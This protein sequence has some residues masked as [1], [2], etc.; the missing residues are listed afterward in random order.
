[1]ADRSLR[2]E[3][4]HMALPHIGPSLSE[5]TVSVEIMG[6]AAVVIALLPTEAR[7]KVTEMLIEALPHHIEQRAREIASGA[8]DDEMSRRTN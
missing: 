1:M 2:D 6:A 7:K 4:L 5:I 3:I 8:F